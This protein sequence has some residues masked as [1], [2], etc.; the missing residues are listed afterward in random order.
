MATSLIKALWAKLTGKESAQGTYFLGEHSRVAH[1]AVLYDGG[2]RQMLTSGG[3]TGKGKPH[4]GVGDQPDMAVEYAMT[5]TGGAVPVLDLFG[6]RAQAET[7]LRMASLTLL[8]RVADAVKVIAERYPL[9][10]R[11][12]DM[13]KAEHYVALQETANQEFKQAEAAAELSSAFSKL[14]D[15]VLATA[16]AE[17][18]DQMR[19]SALATKRHIEDPKY[20]AWLEEPVQDSE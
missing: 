13:S 2:G 17:W 14:G 4:P 11:S 7:I 19:L 18:A 6:E 8:E 3:I 15:S 16:M 12:G 1:T 20:L 9:P 10:D 5:A